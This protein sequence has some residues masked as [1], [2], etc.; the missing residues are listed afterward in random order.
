[1]PEQRFV[2]SKKL[3]NKNK[4]K[5]KVTGLGGLQILLASPKCPEILFVKINLSHLKRLLFVMKCCFSV[6]F[7]DFPLFLFSIRVTG[8]FKDF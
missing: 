4:Q 8:A 5:K 3:K 6:L 2:H 1:M 7:L